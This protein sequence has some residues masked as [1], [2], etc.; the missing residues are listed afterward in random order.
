MKITKILEKILAPSPKNSDNKKDN[1]QYIGS[2]S[3]FDRGYNLLATGFTTVVIAVALL[4][5]VYFVPIPGNYKLYIVE[6]GSMEPALHTGSVVIVKPSANYG[7]GDI[8]TFGGNTKNKTT[9][10]RVKDLE[11]VTG[12]IYYITKGDANNA[13][14]TSKVPQ[15]KVIGKVLFTVPYAGYLIAYAKQPIG[16]AL[17][18]I[19]PCGIII[20]EEVGKIWKEIR[21]IKPDEKE[22]NSVIDK[23]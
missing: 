4:I 20:L 17:L 19:L 14:D 16:F 2:K 18:V 10:H 21:S 1:G 9:T 12:K 23:P 22:H 6:S 13:E 8:I 11:T 7:A 5:V 15:D 3:I